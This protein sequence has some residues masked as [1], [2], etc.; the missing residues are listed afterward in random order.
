[1]GRENTPAGRIQSSL[2]LT[3]SGALRAVT[4]FPGLEREPARSSTISRTPRRPTLVATCGAKTKISY[5]M[6]FYNFPPPAPPKFI[7]PHPRR[8]ALK[9]VMFIFGPGRKQIEETARPFGFIARGAGSFEKSGKTA[10]S[11]I[12]RL[13]L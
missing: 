3:L 6:S 1:M 11:G 13:R 2:I 4:H 12:P 10:S 5:A 9:R 8:A 7:S